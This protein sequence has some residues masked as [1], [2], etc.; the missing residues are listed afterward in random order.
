MW[1][2]LQKDMG[3]GLTILEFVYLDALDIYMFGIE[4]K[5]TATTVVLCKFHDVPSKL[6]IVW[7]SH[8]KLSGDMV[9]LFF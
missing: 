4:E 2:M 3:H 1:F 9:P 8:P 5:P 6:S 7:G